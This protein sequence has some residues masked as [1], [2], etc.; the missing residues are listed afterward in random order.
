MT[1]TRM[2][3]SGFSEDKGLG[4]MLSLSRAQKPGLGVQHGVNGVFVAL[5]VRRLTRSLLS[6][7]LKTNCL[8]FWFNFL[9]KDSGHIVLKPNLI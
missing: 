8:I 9:V 7:K 4:G 1:S 6:P 2:V 5:L 3:S